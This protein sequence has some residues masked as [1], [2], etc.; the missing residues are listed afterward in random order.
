MRALVRRESHTWRAH[1]TLVPGIIFGWA[2]GFVS[3]SWRAHD[4]PRVITLGIWGHTSPH[5]RG[6]AM[7]EPILSVSRPSTLI[8]GRSNLQAAS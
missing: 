4:R 8:L 7:S 3:G 6:I 1:G 5:H 2:Y